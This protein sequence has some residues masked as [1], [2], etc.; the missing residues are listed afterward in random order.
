MQAMETE[1]VEYKLIGHFIVYCYL[2]LQ[3]YLYLSPSFE[4]GSALFDA[5][6]KFCCTTAMSETFTVLEL[7][8]LGPGRGI[9]NDEIEPSTVIR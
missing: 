5:R 1:N 9:E 7:T 2:I 8:R 3:P 4:S 6:R